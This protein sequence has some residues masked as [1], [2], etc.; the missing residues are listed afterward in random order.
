MNNKTGSYLRALSTIS[1]VVLA[2]LLTGLIAGLQ[3]YPQA[4]GTLGAPAA[5]QVTGETITVPPAGRMSWQAMLDYEANN[6]VEA[7]SPRVVPN[8]PGPGAR[9]LDEPGGVQ[10][11]DS[12]GLEKAPVEPLAPP[13]TVSN[14]L[15][16]EDNN[17]SIPPD[18]M[19]AAGPNHLMVML[20]TEV[21]IQTKTGGTISTVLLDTFWTSGTGLTGDPFDPKLVYDTL[22]DRW[23]ATIVADSREVTSAVW[24]AISDTSDPTGTWTFYAI[25]ADP[26]DVNWADYPGFGMNSTW[27]A[28]TN[29]MFTNASDTF[30]GAKMWVLNKAEALAGIGL[31]PTVF[32]IGFDE[33]PLGSGYD[34]FTL[35]PAVTFDP[36][37]S[38]LYIIDNSGYGYGSGRFF[39]R[40]SQITGTGP[41]PVWS[42]VPGSSILA[43]SGWFEVETA[44]RFN[45]TQIDAAQLGTTSLVNTNTPRALNAV[46]RNGR[47][48][49]THS[50]GLPVGTADRT[51]SFWY[52][53]NPGAMPS[54][55][56]QSGYVDNGAG[57]HFFFPSIA[58]NANNDAALGFSYSDATQYVEAAYT[59]RES[60]DTAGTMGTRT[61]C[62]AGE[63]SYV[64]D[65][66]SGRIRWGDY[67]ATVV[68]PVDDLTFWTLQEY[69]ET[70]VG[71]EEFHDRWGTWWCRA[72]IGNV[73]QG[74]EM[75]N[76]NDW[77][78]PDNWSSGA[79]PTCS[80]DALIP[81]NPIGGQFP[82]VNANASVRNLTIGVGA[83]VNMSANT[84][85][86]CGNL[87]NSGTFNGTGGTVNFNGGTTQNL[88]AN[89]ATLFHDLT[90]SSGTTL[91]ETVPADNVT[92]G[93]L[94]ANNGM[95][96]KSQF[97]LGTGTTTFGL[98]G[99]SVDIT[100]LGNLS[101]LAVDKVGSAHPSENSAGGGAD[102]LD[103][104]FDLTPDVNDMSFSLEL[105]LSYTDAELAASPAVGSEENLRLCRWTGM[106]W[107]CPARGGSSNSTTNTVCAVNVSALSDWTIGETGPTSVTLR[108]LGAQEGGTGLREVLPIL[109]VLLIFSGLAAVGFRRRKPA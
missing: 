2:F 13:D 81:T 50:A 86:V 83:T 97:G 5:Q 6:P 61:T 88:T 8:M 77:D 47:L 40:L 95:V 57:T 10:T 56:V 98:V 66:D 23:M 108:N 109:L 104:Y 41:S 49:T 100:T 38:T 45:F 65:F 59:G 51:A 69:A 105:C 24:F 53:I 32:D 21:R 43:G 79:V 54:P 26:S 11:P 28:I 96:S 36:S 1:K 9:I 46:F 17:A 25:D 39:L 14:F 75:G 106:G 89:T 92:V 103:V 34:G 76:P 3:P 93:G 85:N 58:V 55:I 68:D 37:E 16:L 62:K 31:T 87:D 82:T 7:P 60:T 29:N 42:V 71:S 22:S 15:G 72:Q 4:D 12:T 44:N 30:S 48:W 70:D 99:A 102:M 101:T 74:D 35:Q 19:G 67:S 78:D 33:A 107:D 27:I 80:T 20:N 73:W 18:T 94:L 84:L 63:D 91:T 64:K 52:E 90:V